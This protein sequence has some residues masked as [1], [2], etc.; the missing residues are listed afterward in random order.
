MFLSIKKL[1]KKIFNFFIFNSN[2]F[3]KKIPKIL[4]ESHYSV[5]FEFS[6]ISRS[7]ISFIEKLLLLK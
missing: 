5:L 4:L 2:F 1:E 3:K 6:K 7:L